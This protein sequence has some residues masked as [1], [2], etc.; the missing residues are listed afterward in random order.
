M[1]EVEDE[2]KGEREK[3]NKSVGLCEREMETAESRE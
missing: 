1:R 3:Q 2:K